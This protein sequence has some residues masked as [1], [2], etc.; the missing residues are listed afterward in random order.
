MESPNWKEK[1]RERR[2][3][4]WEAEGERIKF[5]WLGFGWTGLEWV[6]NMFTVLKLEQ[7]A[8][9]NDVSVNAAQQQVCLQQ[10]L[11]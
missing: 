4:D 8:L 7:F 9:Q 3:W 10:A 5:G 1:R 2:K 11:Y 6:R